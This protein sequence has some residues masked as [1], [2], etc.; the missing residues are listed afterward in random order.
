M[1]RDKLSFVQYLSAPPSSRHPLMKR[2]S[3]SSPPHSKRAT[4]V[5]GT[6]VPFTDD[7]QRDRLQENFPG[8]SPCSTRKVSTFRKQ[9]FQAPMVITLLQETTMQSTPEDA[10][11]SAGASELPPPGSEDH[12]TPPEHFI[13]NPAAEL[14]INAP[15]SPGARPRQ[16]R[17]RDPPDIAEVLTQQ[18]A[19]LAEMME[20]L[21]NNRLDQ[22]ARPQQQVNDPVDPPEDPNF[23]WER[24]A[25]PSETSFVVPST[26]MVQR[27]ATLLFAKVPLLQGRDQHE[28]RFVLQVI[29][30]CPDLSPEDRQWAFQRL[31]VY[32][33]VAALGWPQPRLACASSTASTDFDLPPGV[34]L[35]QQERRNTRNQA[36]QQPAAAAAPVPAPAPAH[37][38]QGHG[39]Q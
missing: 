32:C 24:L 28:A 29:S 36:P 13:L 19:V 3:K 9:L 23:M 17:A 21:R 1:I 7:L 15:R 37:Q 8:A 33:I 31:N 34:V 16:P 4:A 25:L 2:R 20:Q 14:I 6:P 11:S 10:S 39:G 5:P 27:M 18:T 22:P 30:M 12:F 38:R 26:G 35:P